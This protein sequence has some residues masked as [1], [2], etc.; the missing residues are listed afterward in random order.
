MCSSDLRIAQR[1]LQKSALQKSATCIAEECIA[2][3]RNV[4]Y[5]RVLSLCNNREMFSSV[6]LS[7]PEKFPCNEVI[8]TSPI[9]VTKVAKLSIA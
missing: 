2:E 7:G 8:E 3:E 1:A 5:R 4:H 6:W 9:F